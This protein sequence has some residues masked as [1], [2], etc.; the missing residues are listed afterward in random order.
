MIPLKLTIEGLYSYQKQ[1]IID[2]EEL[3]A[4]GLFGVFGAVGS[5]K[6]SIL[7]AISFALYGV[8]E[9][10]NKLD[11]RSYNMMNL[12]S[13]RSYIEFDFLNSENEKFKTVREYRRNS[14]RFDDVSP[15]H[16]TF[17]KETNGEW[18]PL[19]HTN[20]EEIIGLSYSNFKR[21]II[22]PQGQ[23]KEFLELGVTDRTKMMKEIF[24]L[25]RF[26]LQDK[27]SSLM[28][29]N[30][31]K[32]D[33][34]EGQLSGFEEVN[35]ELLDEIEKRFQE[36]I[37]E[38]NQ[39][40]EKHEKAAEEF[41]KLKDKRNNFLLLQSNLEK[42][43]E[44]ENRE[45]AVEKQ[46]KLLERF[47][48]TRLEFQQIIKSENDLNLEIKSKTDELNTK[49][50]DYNQLK[51][52]LTLTAE[53]LS[54]LKPKFENLEIQ[55]QKVIDL[56]VI[57]DLRN[58]K[59]KIND[60]K[61]RL[62]KG[63][64]LIQAGKNSLTEKENQILKADT[65]L[66]K[67]KENK[68]DSGILIAAEGWYQKNKTLAE[69]LKSK[70]K[71]ILDF[72]KQCD[73]LKLE[74]KKLEVSP[75]SF[76]KD[77]S[78]KLSALETQKQKLIS[79][80]NHLQLEQK[81]NEYAHTLHDGEPC[82]L[83]GSQEHPNVLSGKD[84]SEEISLLK[85]K[86]TKIENE[87]GKLNQLKNKV[88]NNLDTQKIYQDQINKEQNELKEIQ[89]KQNELKNEFV[90]KNFDAE[91]SEKFEEFKK[92][93]L[94]TEKQTDKKQNELNRL[95]EE[96]KEIK[97][98]LDNYNERL[99]EL[100]LSDN[101]LT[102]EFRT[103]DS[104]L[105]TLKF[106]DFENVETENIS[107]QTADL[108]T[109]I[110]KV[111]NDYK[112]T[113]KQFNE[114]NVKESGLKSALES[115]VK[116]VEELESKSSKI[117][118]EIQEKL[119]AGKFES[120]EEMLAVLNLSIN[121]T[122]V[123]KQIDDFRIGFETLKNKINEQKEDLKDFESNDEV[124]ESEKQ[125]LENINKEL[126]KQID[127]TSK[128]EGE[129][130]RLKTEFEKKKELIKTQTELNKRRDNLKILF[131]LFK[132]QGFVNYVS[133]VHLR[134]LC[135][136]ANQRFHRMTRNQLSLQL[137]ENL[138]FEII[139]YLNEG[140]SRSVKTLSGGQSFQVS[141]SLA[142]ALAESVQSQSKSDKNFF[143]IDEGFGTQDSEAVNIV[144]DTLMQL[145]KENRIV[146]IISHVSEL[147]DRIPVSLQIIKDEKEG[148]LIQKN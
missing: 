60:T 89:T 39:L 47:E 99:R 63:R 20:A 148:S 58:L 96:L 22:I 125:K 73:E 142:L 55:K 104:G 10:L 124:F 27:T 61:E 90:W 136:H 70:E 122:E 85:D 84:L 127:K 26:D 2:F 107:K 49:Q 1:Q 56:E 8:T 64:S 72:N 16:S 135:D 65:E 118:K 74:L 123:R 28:S 139:D 120:K 76:E 12:K 83:C 30:K 101:Q 19:E 95:S 117:S 14:K 105:K 130:K 145:Q 126:D 121:P 110:Q 50:K 52:D 114:L 51:E 37:K 45:E 32:L 119:T 11:K 82:P 91:N 59:S 86:Q 71:S 17:Y 5:G 21:T 141:L 143:F 108:K 69:Q 79:D 68:T 140:R 29:A 78:E 3:T 41:R 100:E 44:F 133:G 146:G 23:F 137:N 111:E 57:A 54:V 92:N 13:N 147:K 36:E 18:I 40:K 24:N 35:A 66:K 15:V 80:E 132:G 109:E 62:E 115:L 81:L 103:K 134:Q 34:L 102:T 87:I 25:H 53:K 144:F 42:L 6:S 33:I 46:L 106:I 129:L 97:N 67:L 75:E 9:R 94:E 48:K 116:T 138:D 128:T 112:I 4:A 43:K 31:S 93:S 113:E 38:R 98:K 131:N 7:E 77:F 88:E